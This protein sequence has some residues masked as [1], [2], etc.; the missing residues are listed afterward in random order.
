[1]ALDAAEREHAERSASLQD[2]ID[3][4]EKKL[5]AEDAGWQAKRDRLKAASAK[6]KIRL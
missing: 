2:R 1:M 6:R 3:I 5:R 4:L